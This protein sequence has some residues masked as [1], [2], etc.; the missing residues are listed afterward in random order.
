M[1]T[2]YRIGIVAGLAALVLATGLA[3]ALW[4]PDGKRE[5]ASTVDGAGIEESVQVQVSRAP[6]Q[7]QLGGA[8]ESTS[9]LDG[10][11]IQESLQFQWASR[12]SQPSPGGAR[13]Q[14][15]VEDS[16]EYL[17]RDA[18]GKIKEQGSGGGQ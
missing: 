7:P 1:A 4:L 11:S 5:S 12:S 14:G 13:E 2:R 16:V 6:G 15:R 3:L 17:I 8:R 9:A 18:S 10:A